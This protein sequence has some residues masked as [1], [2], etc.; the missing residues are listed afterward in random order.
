MLLRD[1]YVRFYKS[2]NFDYLRKTHPEAKADAWELT[3]DGFWYPYVRVGLEDGITTVVGANESGKSQLLGAIECALTGRDVKRSDFCRYSQF[4]AVDEAMLRPDF[5]ARFGDLSDDERAAVARACGV[6][7][8]PDFSSFSL[9]RLGRGENTIYLE[10][11]GGWSEHPVADMSQLDPVLPRAFV[12]HSQVPLPDSVPLSFL[13]SGSLDDER[14]RRERRGLLSILLGNW[15]WFE[16][17][18]TVQQQAQGIADAFQPQ[19]A[20]DEREMRLAEDLLIKVARIDRSAFAELKA[21]VDNGEEGYANGIVEKI[22]EKLASSLNFPR[23]WSQDSE[24]KL[25][26]TL[27]DFDLV[28]TIRDRTGTEYSFSERSS[29]LKYFLSYFVQYLAHEPPADGVQ[30]IL[31]MDEPDAYLS[32][33]GQQDLLRIFEAFAFPPNERPACQVVYVTHSPFLIDKNHGERIRVLEKGEG[34]EGTRVVRNV[35]RNHY[36]PLRS[37]FGAFVGETTFISNCNLMLEGMADQILLAGASAELRRKQAPKTENLDLNTITLVPTGSASHIP[38]MTYL[39]RGRDAERPAVIVL[40]DSD[41]AGNTARRDLARGGPRGRQVIEDRFVVQVGELPDEGLQIDNPHGATEIEDL[42]PVQIALSAGRLYV[43]DFLGP[44]EVEKLAGVS[45]RDIDFG[46]A[47]STH[48]AVE[49]ALAGVLGSDFHI[50]KV[51]FARAVVR[52]ISGPEQS[53][54][55]DDTAEAFEQNFRTLF[56]RLG[57]M[58][59]DATRDFLSERTSSRIKRARDSFLLD[60]PDRARRE[61]A[62]VLFEEIDANLGSTLDAE[63]MRL[64]IRRMQIDFGLDHDVSMDIDNYEGFKESLLALAYQERR[65]SQEA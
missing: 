14:T 1:V 57:R 33:Q 18:K 11:P 5:G 12:I 61:D 65:A 53:A 64:E 40:L 24:F 17:A 28:F 62:N 50:D 13:S 34:D 15:G 19:G 54:V 45:T 42:I 9:F 56:R 48:A 43:A 6:A 2:F 52:V 46:K 35:G 49:A 58:Q 38:Y 20:T 25:L 59:R 23:W 63:Q 55:N 44:E 8:P 3:P 16:S 10:E 41:K 36:E 39:A 60:H 27:R 21:A 26:L 22:N 7:S 32:S 4:F 30:E 31:L 47:L 51:G 29:G 37:A